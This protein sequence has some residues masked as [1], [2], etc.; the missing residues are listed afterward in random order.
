MIAVLSSCLSTRI[1]F[2]A[3]ELNM[4]LF[5]VV[6]S[7]TDCWNFVVIVSGKLVGYGA[8]VSPGRNSR[9]DATTI[10]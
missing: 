4:V 10:E 5:F 8:S 7:Y 6:E 3:Y 9:R 1:T 2:K